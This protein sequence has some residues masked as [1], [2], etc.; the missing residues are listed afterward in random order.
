MPVLSDETGSFLEYRQLW[1]HPKYQKIWEESYCNELGC[2]CQGIGTGDKGLKKQRFSVTETF[3]VFW[4]EDV[5]ADIIKEIN[6]VGVVCEVCPQKDH[7]NRTWIT[8][9]DNVIIHLGYVATPTAS[10]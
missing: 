7:P 8:I 2:L 6:Y 1:N 5:P 9:G 4:Y 3:R 10:L